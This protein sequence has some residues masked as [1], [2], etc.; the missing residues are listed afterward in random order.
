MIKQKTLNLD[1]KQS[2]WLIG[3]KVMIG[4]KHS[5]RS[6][7][8]PGMAF[9]NHPVWG[10]DPQPAHMSGYTND[11]LD[12]GG[13]H[14]NSG[15]PNHA[16]Y[17]VAMTLGGYAWEKAGKIWYAA[18]CDKKTVKRDAKFADFKNATLVQAQKLFKTDAAVEKA[19]SDAWTSVGV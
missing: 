18:M 6:L 3:E 15:I 19:V 11:P 13:V 14:L 9:R 8:A 12:N 4:N 7:K 1:V 16:F 17:L 2:N 10:T 5:L